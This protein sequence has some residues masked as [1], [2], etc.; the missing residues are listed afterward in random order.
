MDPAALRLGNM[1]YRNVLN[2]YRR[3]EVDYRRLLGHL[4]LYQQSLDSIVGRDRGPESQNQATPP[5]SAADPVED[6]DVSTRSTSPCR[7][8]VTSPSRQITGAEDRER[9]EEADEERGEEG[10]QDEG[11]AGETSSEDFESEDEEDSSGEDVWYYWGCVEAVEGVEEA[12]DY[13]PPKEIAHEG[14]E[15]SMKACLLD[16]GDGPDLPPPR[17]GWRYLPSS[18]PGGRNQRCHSN[19]TVSS[20]KALVHSSDCT[21]VHERPPT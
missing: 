11:N 18:E 6:Q 21:Q 13:S 5:T 19:S 14:L 16:D 2:E 3:Q 1:S 10:E 9:E 4:S 17:H 15:G 12:W 7:L 8:S 20:L